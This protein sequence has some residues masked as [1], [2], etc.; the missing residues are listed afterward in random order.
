MKKV[1][2]LHQ[3]LPLVIVESLVLK[4]TRLI[5]VW[6]L[7]P[8]WFICFYSLVACQHKTVRLYLEPSWVSGQSN[9]SC[10]SFAQKPHFLS[11]VD[12]CCFCVERHCFILHTVCFPSPTELNHCLSA[13]KRKSIL[14]N[15]SDVYTSVGFCSVWLLCFHFLFACHTLKHT[16]R[17]ACILLLLQFGF[18]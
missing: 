4:R 11:K 2:L 1:A 6:Q 17:H 14:V 7:S 8:M 13:W 9:M 10:T 12:I 5:I 3:S 15:D 16:D 18:F